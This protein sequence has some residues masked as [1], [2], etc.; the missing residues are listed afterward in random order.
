MRYTFSMP[1]GEAIASRHHRTPRGALRAARRL[2]RT[3][4]PTVII[5]EF[6]HASA[7]AGRPVMR[8]EFTGEWDGRGHPLQFWNSGEPVI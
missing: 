7:P 2:V 1:T 3:G 8:I 5:H 6:A 4:R